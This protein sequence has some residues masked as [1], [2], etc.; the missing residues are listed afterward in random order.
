MIHLV[1]SMTHW[2]CYLLY[3]SYD[4]VSDTTINQCACLHLTVFSTKSKEYTPDINY[5]AFSDFDTFSFN[6]LI[7]NPIG[8][9]VSLSLIFIISLFIFIFTKLQFLLP[10]ILQTNNINDDL[11]L[12]S[13]KLLLF[14]KSEDLR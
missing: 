5:Q 1:I 4:Q 8:L 9:I 11:P 10:K 7:N 13:Q 12:V 3:S 14:L 2:G 6:L